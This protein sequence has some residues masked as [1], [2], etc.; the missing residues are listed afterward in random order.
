V[1]RTRLVL[2]G[3]GVAVLL[4]CLTGG[5]TRAQWTGSAAYPG[6]TVRAGDLQLTTG[7]PS[8]RQITPGVSEPASSSSAGFVSMPGDVIAIRVP[9]STYLRGDNIAANLAVD[10]TAPADTSIAAS[11]RVLDAND[12]QVAPASADVPAGSSL[13]VPGLAGNDAGVSAN[14]TVLLHVQVLGDYQWVTPDQPATV[15]DWSAGT[16][17]VELDQIRSAGP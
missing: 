8:W 13:A 14:W 2:A 7:Q 12:T 9:V 6:A 10:Y 4:S 15:T 11:F 17:R 1:N 3:G 16:V 5:S